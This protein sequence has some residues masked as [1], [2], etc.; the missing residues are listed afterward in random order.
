MRRDEPVSAL[1]RR[2]LAAGVTLALWLA[3]LALAAGPMR[4]E[5]QHTYGHL[6]EG[7][8]E[9]LP[10]LTRLVSMPVLGPGGSGPVELLVRIVFWGLTWLGPAAI[11]LA[12]WRADSRQSLV[13]GLLLGSLCY[14]AMMILVVLLVSFGL[15]LPFSLL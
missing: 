14:G 15:W 2:K 4:W 5:L 6:I 10:Q 13:E 9:H 7:A 8:E 11:G 3:V 12:V 1:R